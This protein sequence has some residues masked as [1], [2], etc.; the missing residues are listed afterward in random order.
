[1]EIF[2]MRPIGYRLPYAIKEMTTKKNLL[3]FFVI[4]NIQNSE[5]VWKDK[6]PEDA[7]LD[8]YWILVC[9]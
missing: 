7:H 8:L 3:Q 5:G 1:M 9:I 4:F 6:S 2:T